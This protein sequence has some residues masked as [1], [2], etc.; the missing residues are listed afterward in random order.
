MPAANFNTYNV[1]TEFVTSKCLDRSARRDL[2]ADRYVVKSF[3]TCHK[4]SESPKP[5][6]GGGGE[7]H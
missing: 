3:G 1:A 6:N 7:G 4:C 5:N 2:T